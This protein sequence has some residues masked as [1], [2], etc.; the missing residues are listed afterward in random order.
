MKKI[1]KPYSSSK[2]NFQ[3]KNHLVMAPMTRSR[4]IGNIPND[5]MA[6]YYGQRTGAGL[7]ITEGTSPTPEGLGYPR[8]PG[9]FNRAQIEGWKKITT[10]V[11]RGNSKI[12]IQLMHTGRIGHVDNLP[13]GT[14]LVGPSNIRAKGQIFTDTLG[15]QDHSTPIT[16][17]TEAI[18]LIM[19][20]FATAAKN[21]ISSGFDGIELHGA[22]GYLLE[23]FLN[24]YVNNRTDGYGGNIAN[25]AKLIL[26]IVKRSAQ[27]IGPDKIGIRLSP[28]STLGDLQTYDEIETHETYSYL[29]TELNKIGILYIHISANPNIP[30]RTLDAL[31]NNFD[32]T[33]ILC[34]GLTP[35]TAE[36]TLNAG[37]ADLVAFGRS[38]LANPDFAKR[39]ENPTPLNEVDYNTLYS[40]DEK[41]YI[42]YPFVV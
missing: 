36:E 15:M 25:R 21:A 30:Q 1:L 8:I 3:L 35:E 29:A 11:H 28:F 2:N 41:G 13:K 14:S 39:I 38:F 24:P 32:G 4:A 26:E 23:Q 33:I 10:E 27:E 7:I 9:I 37:F 12:F 40:A 34:N 16:L 20:G 22:N 5:L 17:T 6:E 19:E 31:R 18:E 42:D